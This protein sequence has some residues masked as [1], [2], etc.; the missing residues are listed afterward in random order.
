MLAVGQLVPGAVWSRCADVR[1][2]MKL[3]ERGVQQK[4]PRYI[5][6]AVRCI[7]ALRKKVND[8]VLRGIAVAYYPAS[9]LGGRD[10]KEEREREREEVI[11]CF[12]FPSASPVKDQLLQYLDEVN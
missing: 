10:K 9:E 5:S 4:E 6:R 8:S 7:Q 1:E 11:S 2:Q 3:V 12:S